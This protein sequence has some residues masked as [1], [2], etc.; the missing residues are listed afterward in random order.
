L[1]ARLLKVLHHEVRSRL[2]ETG[3]FMETG[4]GWGSPLRTR[5]VWG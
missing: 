2:A 4:A 1:T 3:S 5:G